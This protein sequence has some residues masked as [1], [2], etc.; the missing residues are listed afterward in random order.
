MAPPAYD[1]LLEHIAT[2][3]AAVPAADNLAVF[4]RLVELSRTS[5]RSILSLLARQLEGLPAALRNLAQQIL[6]GCPH[7][8]ADVWQALNAAQQAAA[9]ESGVASVDSGIGSMAT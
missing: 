8:A 6:L 9:A 3:F 1:D 7:L 5:S 4:Q 2:H